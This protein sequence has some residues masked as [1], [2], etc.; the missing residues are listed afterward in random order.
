MKIDPGSYLEIFLYFH[1]KKKLFQALELN[2]DIF[3]LWSNL[4]RS[5]EI[6]PKELNL[7]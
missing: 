3:I 4:Y 2:L 7:S 1:E 6:Y 5:A